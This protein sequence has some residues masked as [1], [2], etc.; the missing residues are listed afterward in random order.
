[1]VNLRV[2]AF[3]SKRRK[4]KYSSKRALKPLRCVASIAAPIQ[5]VFYQDGGLSVGMRTDWRLGLSALPSTRHRPEADTM[6]V[7]TQRVMTRRTLIH[8]HSMTVSSR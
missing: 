1:V 2:V 6:L 7:Y 3:I 8:K 5:H 4:R